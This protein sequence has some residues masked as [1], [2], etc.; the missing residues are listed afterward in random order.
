MQPPH[1]GGFSSFLCG[2]GS[3]HV[4]MFPKQ[5]LQGAFVNLRRLQGTWAQG[6]SGATKM[7]RLLATLQIN[8]QVQ[9][10]T[11]HHLF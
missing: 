11:A 9:R 6:A 1:V 4:G 5:Q 3:A 7:Q 10:V 8:S 2:H